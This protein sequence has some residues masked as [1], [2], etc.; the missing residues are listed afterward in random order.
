MVM[1]K[2]TQGTTTRPGPPPFVAHCTEL[3]A[4]LGTVRVGR[5][6]GGWGFYVDELFMALIAYDQLY[7]KSD[8]QTQAQFAAAGCVPF[9]YVARDQEKV[10]TSYWSV[11]GEAMDSPALMEPWAR[12]ALQAALRSRKPKR[13]AAKKTAGAKAVK[14]PANATTRAAT[15]PRGRGPAR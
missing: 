7:L 4:P 10:V 2:S 9:A 12:L 1:S 8:P 15:K 14:P 6:F 3:L 13:T 5:M 11:P